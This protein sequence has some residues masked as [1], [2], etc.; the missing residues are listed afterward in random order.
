MVFHSQII[1]PLFW[2]SDPWY[3]GH[4]IKLLWQYKW[5]IIEPVPLS[6]REELIGMHL[7]IFFLDFINIPISSNK[8]DYESNLLIVLVKNF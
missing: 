8:I 2:F 1:S 7:E 4:M 3:K 5:L 6:I